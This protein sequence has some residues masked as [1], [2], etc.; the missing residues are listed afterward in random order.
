[1]TVILF[2]VGRSVAA[3]GNMWC[4]VV[5]CS[6]VVWQWCE[7]WCGVMWCSDVVVVV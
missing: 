2:I 1:M 6:A 3:W 7:V 5:Y 4:G